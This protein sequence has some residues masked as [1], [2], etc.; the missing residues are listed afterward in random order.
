M[1]A[2]TKALCLVP[3]SGGGLNDSLST[4]GNAAGPGCVPDL[5]CQSQAQGCGWEPH[6]GGRSGLGLGGAVA[7]ASAPGSPSPLQDPP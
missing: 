7:Q 1:A 2:L 6:T 5:T 3:G 4:L